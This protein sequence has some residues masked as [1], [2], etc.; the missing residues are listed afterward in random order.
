MQIASSSGRLSDL[1]VSTAWSLWTELGLSG[2]ER[3]HDSEAV[4]VEPL[5][6]FTAWLGR[7]D[8]RLLDETLDWCISNAR[9]VS[10][11]RLNGLLKQLD[12]EVVEAFGDYSAT[13]RSKAPKIKWP[14]E[15]RARRLAPSGKSEVPNLERPALIQLRLRA[16]YGVGARAELL[17]LL[18]IDAQLG[19][20]AA[21]LARESAYTKVNVAAAL[22]LLALTGVVRIEKSGNQH[23]FRLGRGPQLVELAGP[24]PGFQPDWNTRFAV[25][26]P[27]TRLEASAGNGEGAVRA[28]QVVGVLRQIEKPLA[29]LG[30]GD[31]V[32]PPGRSEFIQEFDLWSEQ[33]M[34]YW[35]NQDVRAGPADARYE[36]HR[37]DIAWETTVHEPG[38]GARP[39][40]LPEWEELY[41]EHQRSPNWI[42]DDSVGALKLAHEL[43]RRAYGRRGLAVEPFRYQP[44]VIAFAEQQLRTIPR[45]QS[46]TFSDAFLRLWRAERLGRLSAATGG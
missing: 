21:D 18:L 27:L 4:D 28:A 22:D 40:T 11:T 38:R 29:R 39:L 30:L 8:H 43:M 32:P 3:R 2:W 5:I 33:L 16:L 36:V 23:R 37:A 24:L 12:P 9:F 26:L 10:A 20:S 14:G 34:S 45:G 41:K 25:M 46:R 1:A 19:W 6:L 44:E 17:R 42:E 31:L 7:F 15:G 13:V 35:A